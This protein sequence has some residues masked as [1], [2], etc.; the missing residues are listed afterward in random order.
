[1][2]IR[3]YL[4][5]RHVPHETLLHS[6]SPS[7]AH[8]AQSVHVTGARVAKSVLVRFGAGYV[9]AVLPATHRI[10]MARLGSALQATGLTLATEDEVEFV[11]LDCERGAVPPFG[12]LYHLTTVVDASLSGGNEIVIEGNTRHEGIRLRYRDFEAVENPIRARFADPIA[13]RRK[14]S[15]HRRAG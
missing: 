14:R 6:P 8:L 9:L 11:F 3:E 4:R 5:G 12:S 1:M 13:P 10:D 2:M 7:A 15:S